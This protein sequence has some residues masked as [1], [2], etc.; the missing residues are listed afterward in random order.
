MSPQHHLPHPHTEGGASLGYILEKTSLLSSGAS[1]AAPLSAAHHLLPNAD[2]YLLP[3]ESSLIS[4]TTTSHA[5]RAP[6]LLSQTHPCPS[7]HFLSPLWPCS[8][9]PPAYAM[10]GKV[11]PRK[12]LVDCGAPLGAFPFS[13]GLQSCIV[14]WKPL[15][16]HIWSSFIYSLVYRGRTGSVSVTHHSWN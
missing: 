5:E 12:E 1:V 10:V 6:A 7:S 8:A 3:R 13:Q 11:S 15:A 2:L 9:H 14:C 4:S 16:S